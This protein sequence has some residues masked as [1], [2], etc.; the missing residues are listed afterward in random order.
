M[1]TVRE[2]PLYQTSK[3]TIYLIGMFAETIAA[4]KSFIYH[5]L[6]CSRSVFFVNTRVLFIDRNH[7][8]PDV[9]A[10]SG[11]S[12]HGSHGLDAW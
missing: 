10:W 12:T 2:R 5:R 3:Y 6:L 4:E 9:E 1:R 7:L 11:R 8:L